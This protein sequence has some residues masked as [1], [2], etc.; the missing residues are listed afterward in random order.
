MNVGGTIRALAALAG[1][2]LLTACSTNQ[3][4]PGAPRVSAITATTTANGT[5][6][7]GTQD[8]PTDWT[9][10][11]HDNSRS[12]YAT[13]LAPVGTLSQAWHANLDGAVYGQPLVVDG[14]VLA[15]TEGD[16]VY[17][18]NADTG[19]VQWSAHLGTPQPQS[20]LPCG[21]VDPLG[22]TGTMVYDPATQRVF[23]VAETTGG[24]HTLYGLDVRTGHV[25]V[26]VP[27][28][29]PK[30][31]AIAHQQRAALTVWNG[32]VYI[33][34][35]GLYGDCGNYIG[36][37]VSVTTAGTDQVAYAVPTA[38]EAGIWAPGGGVVVGDSLLY[39]SGNGAAESG[40]WDGSD[41]VLALSPTLARS[42]VFAPASWAD[43]NAADADLGSSSPVL[44]GQWVFIAGKRG[45]GYVL[46]A[47]ALGNVGGQAGQAQVCRSFGDA[48][49]AGDTMYVPCTD[50]P[51]AVTITPSGT[52]SVR[53]QSPVKANGSPTVG[54][55]AVW[56]TD[57]NAGTL[58]ALAQDDGHVVTKIDV[59]QLPHFASPTLSGSK[60]YIGTLNGVVAVAGA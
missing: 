39:S 21:D 11:H 1:I 58:Y 34:Y 7:N 5:T 3:A 29:P 49:V 6:A 31:D 20:G 12:G 56:V 10:Y 41:S 60:A 2:V 48:S 30:G 37:V 14:T 22:I 50:G 52:P 59:G 33:A 15:G 55:G 9:T 32:R 13:G 46:H 16:T 47:G 27:V 23:A 42:D 17:A 19:A 24:A 38:R 8:S 36:S 53:W 54:G 40:A 45:T 18:L 26:R 35:G 51:R 28:E 43:D 25:D 44:L 4:T 57:V